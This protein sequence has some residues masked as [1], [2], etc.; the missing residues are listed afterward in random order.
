MS[1]VAAPQRRPWPRRPTA[2]SGFS[3]WLTTVDHKRIGLMYLVT[4]L[5]ALL[6]GGLFALTLR[7][8]LILSLIH[9]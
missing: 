1:V 3:S 7:L 6:V 4:A 9:I 2:N 8:E 5:V